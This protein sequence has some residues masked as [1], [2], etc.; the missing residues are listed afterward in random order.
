MPIDSDVISQTINI[1]ES[2]DRPTDE[3]DSYWN[4]IKFSN[5]T[6]IGEQVEKLIAK[7]KEKKRK[8]I[9]STPD[10]DVKEVVDLIKDQLKST[11]AQ[12][13]VLLAEKAEMDNYSTLRC[14]E[15][16]DLLKEFEDL[17]RRCSPEM[18]VEVL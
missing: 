2:K 5:N 18:F 14:L 3:G 4:E 13:E 11:N 7:S 1:G 16:L 17:P 8:I 9:S 6:P 10:P 15:T 12:R